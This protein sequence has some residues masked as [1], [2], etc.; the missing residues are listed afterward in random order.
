MIDRQADRELKEKI[1]NRYR[2]YDGEGVSRNSDDGSL[3]PSMDADYWKKQLG[4]V[5]TTPGPNVYLD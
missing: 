4:R 1:I 5:T 3:R 2:F